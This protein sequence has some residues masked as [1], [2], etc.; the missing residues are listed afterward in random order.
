MEIGQVDVLFFFFCTVCKYLQIGGTGKVSKT[1]IFMKYPAPME[2]GAGRVG[3][4][5]YPKAVGAS[6]VDG[7]GIF[8]VT[9]GFNEQT[10]DNHLVQG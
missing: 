2:P 10:R 8:G 7:L 5:V 6:L 1:K 4:P 9:P 3:G